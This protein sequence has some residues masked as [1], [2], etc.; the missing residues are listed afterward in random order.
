MEMLWVISSQELE[1]LCMIGRVSLVLRSRGANW[2]GRVGAQGGAA[3][4][5]VGKGLEQDR[6]GGRVCLKSAS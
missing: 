5:A 2:Q 1:K 3:V 4:G 6:V